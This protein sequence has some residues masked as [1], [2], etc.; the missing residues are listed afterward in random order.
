MRDVSTSI[1][2][3]VRIRSR[4][5]ALAGTR[6]VASPLLTRHPLFATRDEHD[7]RRFLAERSIAVGF[8]PDDRSPLDA[9]V[10]GVQLAGVWLGHVGY[11]REVT[12]SSAPRRDDYWLQLPTHGR[13][14]VRVARH[15]LHCDAHLGAVLS[16]G[17]ETVVHP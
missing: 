6:S 3:V 17:V 14:D 10:N 2:A 5:P 13:F 1:S 7:L 16:P 12:L 4:V 15:R 11:G 9:H 8:P